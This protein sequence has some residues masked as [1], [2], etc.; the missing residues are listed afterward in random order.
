MTD[1]TEPTPADHPDRYALEYIDARIAQYKQRGLG[2]AA[3]AMGVLRG[4][5]RAGKP[6]RY[7]AGVREIIDDTL[8]IPADHPDRCVLEYIDAHIAQ[9]KSRGL[10]DAAMT[11]GVL[12][13]DLRAGLHRPEQVAA[14]CDH[15]SDKQIADSLPNVGATIRCRLCGEHRAVKP[16]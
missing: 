8:R 14:P 12:R 4:D 1:H 13:G 15:P 7:R 10:G 9:Y 2:E 11:L 6:R 3:M 5:L 16:A